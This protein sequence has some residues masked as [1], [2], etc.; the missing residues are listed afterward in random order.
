MI[1]LIKIL[2]NLFHN[3][4]KHYAGVT[5]TRKRI[6]RAILAHFTIKTAN[7]DLFCHKTPVFLLF[8]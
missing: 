8:Q 1:N 4:I 3:N 7:F 6:K 2:F 5:D